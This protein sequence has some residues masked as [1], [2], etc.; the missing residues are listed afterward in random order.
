V[1]SI[2]STHNADSPDSLGDDT[3]SGCEGL[4][5]AFERAWREDAP[6]AIEDYLVVDDSR[7]P[8]LLRE[9]VH[10]DLELRVKAGE[11][12]CV[13]AYLEHYPELA[14]DPAAVLDLIAAEYELRQ[15]HETD[16]TAEEYCQRFP[17]YR[18]W[19]A[20]RLIH[21]QPTI[22][23][24][25][26]H[27]H[28]LPTSPPAVPGYEIVAEIGRGG[29]GVVYQA[30]DSMLGRN[31]ALK[32]LPAELAGEPLLMQRFVREAQTASA[33]NHPHICTVHALSEHDGRPF[34]VL[35]FIEG[36]TLRSL[37][38]HPLGIAEASRLIRQAAGAL[39]AAH[40]AGVVHR[41]I[42]PENLMVR[43]DGYVKVLDF[44][45]ARRLP[46][47]TTPAGTG[48]HD[49]WPGAVL[50]TVA[51]MSPEQ[52]RGKPLDGASDIF[53]LGIVLYLLVA[54][55]HP[56]ERGSPF[57]TLHAIA[58]AEPA[59]PSRLN[60]AAPAQ[61]EGLIQA[62]LQ[63]DPRLRPTAG[64][65]E[66]GLS[67]MARP[68]RAI[69][70]AAPRSIVHREMELD[71]L[72][73]SLAAAEA[74]RGSM[75]CV[76]GEPGIGKTTLVEDFF[77]ELAGGAY[78]VAR[79]R[80]SERQ[81]ASSAYLP[82]IDALA[83]LLR[84][85]ARSSV[86]RL[87]QVVAPTWSAQMA[88][89]CDAGEQ[90]QTLAFSQQAML[91]EFANL[92][93]EISRLSPVVLFVD[94]V[95]WADA[96]TVDL[97]AYIGRQ[98]HTLSVLIVATYRPTELLLGPHP[99]HRVKL[100]LQGQG[101][102]T[103][104]AVGF[105]QPSQIDRYLAM[106]FPGHA[107]PENFAELVRARTEG[108]PLFMVDLLRYLRE[109]N[110][111]AESN[112]QW[113][114]ARELPDLW[115]ELPESARSMIQR[116]LEQLEEDDRRLLAIAAAQGHEFDS[117][118]V[119]AAAGRDPAEVEDRLQ[120][121]ERIHGLVRLLR[122]DEFPDRTLTLRYA[123]VHVL[124]QQ[125]LFARLPPS[126]RAAISRSL[127]DAW[128]TH[129]G[130]KHPAHAAE[131]AALFE[132]GRDFHSAARQLHLAAHNAARV[133]AH[134]EAIELA[135]R[136]LALLEAL[137][138]SPECDALE[139]PLQTTLG[140]QL[141]VTEGYA[142]PSAERAYER[143]RELC[144]SSPDALFP[145]LWGLWLVR[146]VRSQ[147]P[148]AQ[149]LADELLA[150]AHRLQDLD[151]ALQ[152]H[153]ALGLTALC[154]G[155]PAAA[156]QHVEQAAVLYH[157]DRHRAHAFLFGQDPGVICK[158][159]GAVALWLLG[160]P[161]A[162]RRQ[163]EEA[164]AMSQGLSPTSQSVALHFAAMV[165]QLSRD[166]RRA[167]ECAEASAAISHEHGFRFWLAGGTI[168]GGWALAAGGDASA[169][170]GR[171]QHGLGDWKATGSI[172]YVTYYLALLA[173]ALWRQGYHE[174]AEQTVDEALRLAEHTDERMV[175]PELFR[176]RG[177]LRLER[178]EQAA[179]P[180][181]EAD[182]RRALTV[183]RNQQARSLELR[184]AASLTRLQRQQGLPAD[185][186][187]QLAAAL[188]EFTEGQ[189]SPDIRE[190]QAL[191]RSESTE[192]SE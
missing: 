187:A 176:L 131:L 53:S 172:T 114:L 75:V 191:L 112:G 122:E 160:Y 52:A 175:E 8:Q 159:Y 140:L 69:R 153:Q 1:N 185:G 67:A 138:D 11:Q 81:S 111:I 105:L 36:Q 178:G 94:D 91:R 68:G 23:P 79:G 44:G 2:R 21:N 139:L 162:A 127:A 12:R 3:W 26:A 102:C 85:E 104:L 35:E 120:I 148:Q 174:Q 42:K 118:V 15:R 38:A 103:E 137:P 19:V 6:P 61:L 144:A 136:G 78:L 86:T 107:F 56:F 96:S 30:R 157:P 89:C 71:T 165:F 40:A 48:S 169:G 82:V 158:A 9:L 97:L 33:L 145:V 155:N 74:G 46:T 92:L 20:S 50:G 192:L 60:P 5:R 57:D 106:A 134:H 39:A 116:K 142:A 66:R 133:F 161:D 141:Q 65:V 164:I 108:S 126:R 31:V 34:I 180:Q 121:L 170:L 151:L 124:Y 4:I 163:S 109:R 125:A 188:G 100:E 135:R 110:V 130:D 18:S 143:A 101:V 27:S 177:E 146:K 58:N 70:R 154:R 173:D 147:L 119:A 150:L 99:F 24:A 166:E 182:F 76:Y 93:A 168:I 152:A 63:K 16:L 32:F 51:Y 179:W 80:C 45:L 43:P 156:M 186:A 83:D 7:R 132:A 25:A 149:K 189:Q 181:A 17:A 88:L 115:N 87:M 183:A 22:G 90:C 64:D 55:K 41:D 123:F 129:L 95:H 28:T 49:T 98:C 117:A 10:V 29:M 54:G 59:P 62:M 184:A 167:R 47:L 13:E 37:A 72:R 171:L 84:G 113:T 77:D 128:Q 190:A 14:G 73:R